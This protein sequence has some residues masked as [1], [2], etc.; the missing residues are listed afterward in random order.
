M[1]FIVHIIFINFVKHSPDLVRDTYLA[2]DQFK[3][4]ISG[5]WPKKIVHLCLTY[6]QIRTHVIFYHEGPLVGIVPCLRSLSAVIT[7]PY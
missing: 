6:I 5:L 4:S 3:R 1:C 2:P 7:L